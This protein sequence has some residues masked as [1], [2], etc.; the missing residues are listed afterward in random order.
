MEWVTVKVSDGKP[1]G[2]FKDLL[3]GLAIRGIDKTGDTVLDL[4]FENVGKLTLFAPRAPYNVKEDGIAPGFTSIGLFASSLAIHGY[5]LE[6]GMDGEIIEDVRVLPEIV[7]KTLSMKA[8]TRKNVK[9]GESQDYTDWTVDAVEEATPKKGRTA[10]STSFHP[11]GASEDL[12]GEW[13]VLLAEN[14]DG[15]VTYDE[16]GVVKLLGTWVTDKTHKAALNKA[17]STA[18]KAMFAEGFL[19]GTLSGFTLG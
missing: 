9:G 13:K 8:T 12:T 4:E 3:K 2:S 19:K 10:A 18:F 15:G 6:F 16:G 14:L 5:S 17:R 1:T 7:G 11:P